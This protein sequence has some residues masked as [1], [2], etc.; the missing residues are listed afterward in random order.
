MNK[1]RILIVL[2]VTLFLASCSTKKIALQGK[3]TQC[4]IWK[5]AALV[6][7]IIAPPKMP[8]LPLIDAAIYREVVNNSAKEIIATHEERIDGFNRMVGEKLTQTSGV[9][10]LYGKELFES[11]VYQALEAKGIPLYSP[12]ITNRYFTTAIIPEGSQNFLNFEKTKNPMDYF[13]ASPKQLVRPSKNIARLCQALNVDGAVFCTISVSTLGVGMF[14]TTGPRQL[15]VRLH[16][17]NRDGSL[18]F[19]G[20]SDSEA[21]SSTP[22]DMIHYAQVLDSFEAHLD[23]LMGL[24]YPAAAG[25]EP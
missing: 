22:G 6:E 10:I 13:P 2:L 16:Y 18:L 8:V 9:E 23:E 20:A 24:I 12:K 14:G 7:T 4:E 3:I 19:V 25:S 11:E 17:F 15:N 21:T 5:K 1:Q